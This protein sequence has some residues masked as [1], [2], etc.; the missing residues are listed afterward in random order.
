[1]RVYVEWA[2][3]MK[4]FASD[5]LM[6]SADWIYADEVTPEFIQGGE[7]LAEY[8]D[9]PNTQYKL[10]LY[11]DAMRA[12]EW[13]DVRDLAASCPFALSLCTMPLVFLRD[14]TLY[15]G[16]H[17]MAAMATVD[18]PFYAAEVAVI[19]GWHDGLPMPTGWRSDYKDGAGHDWWEFREAMY[20]AMRALINNHW[21]PTPLEELYG[22]LVS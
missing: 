19:R 16:K 13:K 12:G 5:R 11:R 21:R 10:G 7:Y 15:E 17:R 1:M 20:K 3:D 4:R 22:L 8:L 6:I 18:L 14:G 2:Q 9:H